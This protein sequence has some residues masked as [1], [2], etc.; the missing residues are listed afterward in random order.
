[1]KLGK[2]SLLLFLGIALLTGC[3]NDDDSLQE[4]TLNGIWN[5]N[6]ISGGIAGIDNGYETGIITWTFNNQTLTVEN[7]AA[8]GNIYNGF[9]SGTYSYLLLEDENEQFI[10]LNESG[11][12]LKIIIENN[13]MK[14]DPNDSRWLENG[15][16]IQVSISDSYTFK[17]ER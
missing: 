7:N 2:L 12:Y 5:V 11:D 4:E 13:E 3:S 1:M 6:N 10:N 9:E 8:Q 15:E 17:F 14:I 16:I